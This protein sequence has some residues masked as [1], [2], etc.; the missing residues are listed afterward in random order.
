M[1]PQDC[2]IEVGFTAINLHP[3]NTSENLR[4]TLGVA[5]PA[6]RQPIP[7]RVTAADI[8]QRSCRRA[9]KIENAAR[10]LRTFFRAEASYGEQP[11]N[12]RR[13]S[14]HMSRRLIMLINTLM[15]EQKRP[16]LALVGAIALRPAQL[17]R[18]TNP[19]N[20]QPSG[21][22]SQSLPGLDYE[23]GIPRRT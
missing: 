11:A 23:L 17:E 20:P 19:G 15:S 6:E 2:S 14:S 4:R 7:Q 12:D 5:I 16:S 1:Y 8:I 21:L 3:I 22:K 10:I 13:S 9:K 18:F